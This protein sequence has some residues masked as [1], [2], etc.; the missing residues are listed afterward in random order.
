[1]KKIIL[2]IAVTISC[3]ATNAQLKTTTTCATISVDLL[4]GKVNDLPLG[5]QSAEL[6][7][8]L[9]CFTGSVEATDKCGAAVIYKDKDFTYF[10]T[11]GYV[12]IGE[13]FKGKLSIPLMGAARNSL[14]K[15]L[16]NPKVKDVNW[17]AYTTA[18]GIMIVY[19]NKAN[20]INKI[21]FSNQS[22]QTIQLC[23]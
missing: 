12:E 21:Q 8:I 20:K 11:R 18:Y 9:P 4:T 6:K 22:E 13:K 7:K 14:F 17:D 10:T 3:M 19:F 1:M 23:E 16:G 2:A 5:T 15:L